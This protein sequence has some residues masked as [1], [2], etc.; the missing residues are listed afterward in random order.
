MTVYYPLKSIKEPGLIKYECIPYDVIGS[1]KSFTSFK[2]KIKFF[3][4]CFLSKKK[5][6]H[7]CIKKEKENKL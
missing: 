4:K 5:C 3:S 2:D 7:Y 1:W 6:M